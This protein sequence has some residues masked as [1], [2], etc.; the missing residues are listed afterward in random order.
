MNRRMILMAIAGAFATQSAFAQMSPR[1]TTPLPSV[2]VA[3]A[4]Q[5][6]RAGEAILID[7]RR[8]EEWTDTGVAEGA[9]K[10]DMTSPTFVARLATIRRENPG[11]PIDI[12][13]R[14]AN[15]T[16]QLQA[17]LA[18]QGWTNIVNVRGGMLGNP[19]NPGWL[20]L[21]LPVVAHR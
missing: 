3:E 6:A 10:L 20:A 8:P 13:C 19:G 1:M 18:A 4:H 9:I 17:T 21:G 11:K 12:I 14:T 5:R 16:A 15:R 2:S 7:I